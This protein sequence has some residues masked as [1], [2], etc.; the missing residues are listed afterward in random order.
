MPSDDEHRGIRF[1]EI[2]SAARVVEEAREGDER[3][4]RREDQTKTLA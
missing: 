2:N 1:S 3:K 4:Q